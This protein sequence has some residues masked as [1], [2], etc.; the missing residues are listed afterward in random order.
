VKEV[1]MQTHA[2]VWITHY[3]RELQRRGIAP[4]A[5]GELNDEQYED[6]LG[7]QLFPHF[8]G[9]ATCAHS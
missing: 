9:E 8:I 2:Q 6:V 5:R 3:T 7:D 4:I 1:I